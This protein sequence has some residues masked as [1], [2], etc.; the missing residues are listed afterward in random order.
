MN[1]FTPRN[2]LSPRC[3]FA[4]LDSRNARWRV[5]HEQFGCEFAMR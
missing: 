3:L 5:H 1:K 2:P 4:P